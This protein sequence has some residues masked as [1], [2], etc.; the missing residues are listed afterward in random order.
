MF[1]QAAN[2]MRSGLSGR[3]AAKQFGIDQTTFRRY[4][5]K[6]FKSSSDKV[7]IGYAKQKIFHGCNG[8]GFSR[9]FH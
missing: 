7:K 4:I 9:T 1:E 8:E 3:S 6:V 5:N 2:A